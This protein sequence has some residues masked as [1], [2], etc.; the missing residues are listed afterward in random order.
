ME[1]NKR[2]CKFC[3]VLKDRI[4]AGKFPN[5][6]DKKWRDESGKLWSGKVCG[7]CNNNRSKET[8]RKSR[9]DKKNTPSS[10]ESQ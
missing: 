4:E 6:K 2:H 3:G 8:M 10:P 9:D 5:G 1:I 7:E